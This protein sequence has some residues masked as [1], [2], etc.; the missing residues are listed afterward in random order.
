MRRAI[1][2]AVSAAVSVALLAGGP[3]TAAAAAAPPGLSIS[4]HNE[5]GSVR[6]GDRL[7]YAATLRNDGTAAVD[8]RLVVTVPAYARITGAT[9]GDLDGSDA[10]WTVEVPAGASVTK[11]V[12]ATVGDIPKGELRVTTLVSLYLGDAT[13]PAI[14][15]AEADAIAGVTDP[16]RAVGEQPVGPNRAAPVALVWIGVSAAAVLVAAVVVV[17]WR[18]GRRRGQP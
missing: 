16:A 8:G 3:A 14:R 2:V 9:G 13:Q 1:R 6:S 12:S 7:S 15:S 11:K 18:F 10:S 17:A 5:S 4:I